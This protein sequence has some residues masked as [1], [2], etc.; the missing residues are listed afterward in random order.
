MAPLE[1]VGVS[2]YQGIWLRAVAPVIVSALARGLSIE[3]GCFGTIGGKHIGLV[4]LA[5]LRAT[6]Q[7]KAE[8][9]MK[10]AGLPR[11]LLYFILHS[12]CARPPGLDS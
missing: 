3:C 4:N 12:A 7:Q 8:S 5:E 10:N 6:P 1:Q 9:R 11:H 2:N